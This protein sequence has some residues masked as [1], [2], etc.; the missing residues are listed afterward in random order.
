MIFSRIIYYRE[1]SLQQIDQHD[2]INRSKFTWWVQK[3]FM[4]L[5]I[6]YFSV[7]VPQ[8]LACN[9]SYITNSKNMWFSPSAFVR[10]IALLVKIAFYHI[11][12]GVIQLF[13]IIDGPLGVF[14]HAF[15]SSTFLAIVLRKDECI[16]CLVIIQMYEW[17]LK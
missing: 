16:W 14:Y 9:A 1:D 6:S 11:N 13:P 4:L 12:C 10:D 7:Q 8:F 17:T 15:E 3:I 5:H 2:H